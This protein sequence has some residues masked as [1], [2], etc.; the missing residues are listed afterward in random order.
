[1]LWPLMPFLGARA[2]T[3]EGAQ[4]MFGTIAAVDQTVGLHEILYVLHCD[5]GD[6]Q[7]LDER[8][9]TAAVA[10]ALA[11][12]PKVTPPLRQLQR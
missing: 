6:L 5:D 8:A 1:M 4:V 10:L 3:R 12:L 7:H 11:T 9:T 2:A